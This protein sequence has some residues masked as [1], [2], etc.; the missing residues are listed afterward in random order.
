MSMNE[1]D[2]VMMTSMQD[3][4]DSHLAAS[5]CFSKYA[6]IMAVV[7]ANSMSVRVSFASHDQ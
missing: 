2:P 6:S 7:D 5:R 1:L 4:R 3:D